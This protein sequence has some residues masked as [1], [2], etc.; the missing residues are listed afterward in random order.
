[1]LDKQHLTLREMCEKLNA[2]C[3]QFGGDSFIFSRREADSREWEVSAWDVPFDCAVTVNTGHGGYA[4]GGFGTIEV[5]ELDEVD[6][7]I[8][9]ISETWNDSDLAETRL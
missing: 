9:Y 2:G 7:L 3:P 8:K 5:F 4:V 6:S 1:M